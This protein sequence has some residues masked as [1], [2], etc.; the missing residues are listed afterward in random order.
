MK[1]IK[2]IYLLG[3][4]LLTLTF[5]PS[6]EDKDEADSAPIKVTKIYLEDCKSTVTDR[7]I[8][9]ARLGQL[10]RIEGSGFV[11]M[12]KVYINGYD[13]YFN[14][15]YI[16][17][18]SMMISLSAKTPIAEADEKERNTIRFVKSG[19]EYVYE[20]V[21]R[22]SSPS[23]TEV[24]NTLP[25]VGEKVI[26]YG[27]NL[28]ETT[29]ITLPGNVVITTGIESDEDGEWYS[30]IMPDGV[31]EGG[32]VYSEG[33]NGTA[34][35]PAYF[36]F[37][38]G[39][40]LNFDG[41]GNQ[42]YWGWSETGSMINADDLA[43]DPLNSGRGKCLQL[44]PDRILN[45]ANG[46]IIAGKPRATECWTA[47]NDDAMDDWSRLYNL[48][49]A[50]TPVTDVAF[51]FDVYVPEAWS[52]T[53]HI[54]IVLFNNF[55]F[56][57]LGSDDQGKQTAFYAPYIQNGAIVPFKTTGWLTVTIPFSEFGS[58]AK[59]LEDKEAAVPTFENVVNERLAATYR[60]FGM[61]L[62][63]TDFTFSGVSVTSVLM[64]QKIFVDNWRIVPYKAIEISDFND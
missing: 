25:T 26:V 32:S 34:A 36:N 54:E 42:G 44:I 61:G 13:T 15:T 24:S 35:T 33:A 39:L 8:E 17:D 31:T 56:A 57:G 11:G 41:V 47:G 3:L 7:P 60:N 48:I 19:T 20:F 63:N 52:T 1:K 37:S 12:K 9:F 16:T 38:Q 58:Y 46:G 5:F 18:N 59:T 28:Q 49:P 14:S 22:A 51:Q 2:F 29:K 45:G 21:I 55:N 30:F 43:N 64:N 62:V 40:L 10:I 50:T 23:I 27:S 53:G 4:S 6:C